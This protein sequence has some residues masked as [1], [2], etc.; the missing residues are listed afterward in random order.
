M[1][2]LDCSSKVKVKLSRK[3]ADFSTQHT[4]ENPIPNKIFLTRQELQSYTREGL[5]TVPGAKATIG[6]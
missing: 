6:I 3:V 4:I 1:Q 2:V 5:P